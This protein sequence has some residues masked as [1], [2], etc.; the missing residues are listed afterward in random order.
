MDL[1]PKVVLEFI[2]KHRNVAGMKNESLGEVL[3][4]I[5]DIISDKLEG[6]D[7]SSS[8]KPMGRED[9]S[10]IRMCRVKIGYVSDIHPAA[11]EEIKSHFDSKR[12]IMKYRFVSIS[13]V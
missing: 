5:T 2:V 7:Y 6:Y 13:A 11:L 8:I 9:E 3:D 12:E 4:E 10:G 1:G